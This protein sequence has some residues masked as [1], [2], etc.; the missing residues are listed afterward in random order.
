LGLSCEQKTAQAH[1]L[2]S[3]I[4]GSWKFS[5]EGLADV[6]KIQSRNAPLKREKAD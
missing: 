5:V 1:E 4:S 2:P 3:L 6:S